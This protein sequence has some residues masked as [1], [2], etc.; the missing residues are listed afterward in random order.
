MTEWTIVV[1]IIVTYIV[2]PELSYQ[3]IISVVYSADDYIGL[4]GIGLA[5]ANDSHYTYIA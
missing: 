1:H 4:F 2:K 3:S 5:L